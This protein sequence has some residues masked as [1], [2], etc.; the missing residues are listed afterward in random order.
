[1]SLDEETRIA[2]KAVSELRSTVADTW[3]NNLRGLAL[4]LLGAAPALVIIFF[5]FQPQGLRAIEVAVVFTL[6]CWVFT[7]FITFV[8]SR[9]S[10]MWL[11]AAAEREI[12]ELEN[13]RNS[14]SK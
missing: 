6:L 13:K 11:F 10:D 14:Q 8:Y 9:L 1:M 3:R 7:I 5:L 2:E 4:S 12:R